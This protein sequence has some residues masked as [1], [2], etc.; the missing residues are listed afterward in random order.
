MSEAREHG[1]FPLDLVLL[2]GEARALH[3]FEVRYR[4]LFA[5]CVL[6]AAPFVVVREHEG[7][8]AAVGCAAEFERLV[9]RTE[10]GRVVVVVRGIV[11]VRIGAPGGPHLY[12]S[13][14]C[15]PEADDDVAV[16]AGLAAAAVSAF[17]DVAEAATGT[18][19]DPR[20]DPG[21]PLSYAAAGAVELPGDVLQQLLECRD[22][23]VRL[24]AV[25]D[26]LAAT[27]E[28]LGEARAAA[29]RAATNGAGPHP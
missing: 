25:R 20:V 17:R 16:D 27:A 13:A 8:R 26:A 4:Q 23:N 15:T 12:E 19:R 9:Q 29:R 10:D 6:A 3:V 5:D 11:P 1:L 21:V 2:P 28:G 18:P 7:A 24:A 14:L 22:E